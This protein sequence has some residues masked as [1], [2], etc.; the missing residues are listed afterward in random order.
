MMN[1]ILK[2]KTEFIENYL[3]RLFDGLGIPIDE[4][5]KRMERRIFPGGR[6]TYLF[7]GNLVLEFNLK[8]MK[9]KIE[10]IFKVI[11]V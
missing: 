8:P 4:A 7:D 9:D 1:N 11:K 6:E 5:L 10:L 3:E 2:L